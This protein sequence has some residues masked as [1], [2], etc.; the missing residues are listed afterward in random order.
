MRRLL[1]IGGTTA[2]TA[3]PANAPARGTTTGPVPE[4]DPAS[5]DVGALPQ[6]AR[7]IPPK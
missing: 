3:S 1:I 7:A 6:A 4:T 2:L 5:E